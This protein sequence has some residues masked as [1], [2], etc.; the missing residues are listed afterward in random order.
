MLEL[1]GIAPEDA[2][3]GQKGGDGGASWASVELG[4]HVTASSPRYKKSRIER[5]ILLAWTVSA[6][7]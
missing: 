6:G 5:A 3:G 2:G 1:D 7:S 4:V